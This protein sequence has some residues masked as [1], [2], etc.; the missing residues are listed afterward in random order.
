MSRLQVMHRTLEA[1]MNIPVIDFSRFDEG[2]DRRAELAQEIYEAASQV[3]FMG[4]K[5]LGIDQEMLQQVYQ[6][7]EHFFSRS[8][9]EKQK[10]GYTNAAD[11][12]GFLGM[13]QESLDPT[14]PPDLKETFT[15]RAPFKHAVG[16]TRWPSA[17]FRDLMLEFYE[18]SLSQAFKLLSV[19]CHSLEVPEDFFEQGF[20]GENT[21]LRL[22][23]YPT[24]GAE[25]SSDLQLGA[26]AHTDYGV[27]T[28]L[29]QDEAGGL[30]VRGADGD[31]IPVE[32]EEGVIIINT[33]DLI[34]RWTNGKFRSTE[35]RVQ[36]KI[37]Q[38]ERYSIA[39][40]IDPDNDV[41]VEVLP[42]CIDG[43]EPKYPPT[44][45]RQHLMEKLKAT[46]H[47]Y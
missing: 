24:R 22:L 11:N 35:H 37:G 19:F 18:H 8:T 38:E 33:G 45:V 47:L 46:H 17:E 15:M 30:E 4:V 41:I 44:T 43:D 34:E 21:A 29:F 32:P 42:S 23:Y 2:P 40:F 7:S 28:L 1:D 20:S 3:G 6:A 27:I 26:G 5:N 31:W 10:H 36:P 25:V 12:F 9:T 13:D 39:L 16:D 14:T